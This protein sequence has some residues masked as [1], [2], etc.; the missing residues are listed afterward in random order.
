MT[1]IIDNKYILYFNK[2]IGEGGFSEV[3]SGKCLTTD[4]IVAI[5]CE[6]KES[7]KKQILEK[8]KY[9]Y[10][11]LLKNENTAKMLFY[12]EDETYRY[13][14]LEKYYMNLGNYKK[15]RKIENDG[16]FLFI[17]REIIKQIKILHDLGIIH[18]DIKPENFVIDKKNNTVKLID[19]GLS[20][21]FLDEN[22]KHVIMK[23]TRSRSGTLRYM[24]PNSH[25]KYRLSRRDDLISLSYSL[26]FLY[27][28]KL[29][30]QNIIAESKKEKYNKVLEIKTK[31]LNNTDLLNNL[32]EPIAIIYK[33]SKELRFNEKPKY[34]FLIDIINLCCEISNININKIKL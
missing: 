4:E 34:E 27:K 31:Y 26:I 22:K 32:P 21:T 14:V 2:K 17:T 13:L 18:K 12:N 8:E 33:Y 3:F 16:K 1:K 29:P 6:K 30:W 24:S 11:I 23:K 20:D 19:F 15:K 7:I 10:Q 9:I 25:K 28:N 5:K